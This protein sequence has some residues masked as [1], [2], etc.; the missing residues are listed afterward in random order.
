MAT[1]KQLN[2]SD[3][4]DSLFMNELNASIMSVD[5][6]SISS[7]ARPTLSAISTIQNTQTEQSLV[8]KDIIL[9]IGIPTK[10]YINARFILS[11]FQVIQ[12]TKGIKIEPSILAG[13]SN[14]DQARSILLTN[15]YDKADSNDLFLFIDADQTYEALDIFKA[16]RLIKLEGADVACGA[17]PRSDGSSTMYALNESDFKSGKDNRIRFGA[18]GFMMISKK[19]VGMVHKW[20]IE[21]ENP[22]NLPECR[23]FISSKESEIIPFF[24]QRFIKEFNNSKPQWLGEDY[25]FCYLIRQCGG[26]IRGFESR[27]LGHEVQKLLTLFDNV[28]SEKPELHPSVIK[29]PDRRRTISYFT[30]KSVEKWSPYSLETGIGGSETAV[31]QL[32]QEWAKHGYK[33]NVYG[34]FLD[35]LIYNNVNYIPY[36]LVP[37]DHDILIIWRGSSLILLDHPVKANKIILDMHDLTHLSVLTPTRLAKVNYICVKSKYHK[38]HFNT[39]GVD[40][41]FVIIPNGGSVLTDE[42]QNI[43]LNE[44]KLENQRQNHNPQIQLPTRNRRMLL[45]TSSYDRGLKYVLRYSWPYIKSL[46]PAAEFHIYYGWNSFDAFGVTPEKTEFKN[47]IMKLMEQPGVFHHGRVGQHEL[48]KVRQQAGFHYYLGTFNEIDCISVRESASNGCIPIV[49]NIAAFTDPSRDYLIT[50]DGQVYDINTH[51]LA[52]NLVIELINDDD[53]YKSI[54]EKITTSKKLKS[55]TWEYVA[56][57][58]IAN[59]FKP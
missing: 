22:F 14:I 16:F 44:N 55:E 56:Q 32:S 26:T 52:A 15:W 1:I 50:I 46:L 49:A 13:K 23:Y 12:K 8:T 58:W 29:V 20:L 5:S 6:T 28:E 27:T 51:Y 40:H 19:A 30:G 18:T 31:I 57:E 53:K 34:N 17:Y 59:C 11:L 45:W 36:Q 4:Y 42:K 43:A 39:L 3:E 37:I 48:N 38:Q 25:S 47:K 7:S 41:K 24:K 9:T 35:A 54:L 33:V 10:T 2:D 21:N